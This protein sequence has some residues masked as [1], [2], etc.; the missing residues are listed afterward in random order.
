MATRKETAQRKALL[1]RDLRAARSEGWLAGEMATSQRELARKYGLSSFTVRQEM[2]LLAEEGVLHCVPR[3]GT[4]AGKQT[5]RGGE[6]YLLLTRDGGAGE[7]KF[8]QI[9]SGFEAALAQRGDAVLALEKSAAIERCRRRAMPP[10]VGI[11]DLAYWAYEQAWELPGQE[12]GARVA[13]AKPLETRPGYDLVS[14]DEVEGG[15]LAARHLIE[16]GHRQIAFLGVHSPCGESGIVQWS[17]QRQTGWREALQ[18]EGL[19]ADAVFL[20]ARDALGIGAPATS[21]FATAQEFA[22]GEFAAAR[23]SDAADELAAVGRFDNH[24]LKLVVQRLAFR[25]DI[26]AVVCA[27]DGAALELLAALRGARIEPHQWPAIVGFDNSALAQQQSITS[28]QLPSDELGRAAGQ[29]LW[30]RHNLTEN[31]DLEHRRVPMRLIPRLSSHACWPQHADYQP[32]AP[33]PN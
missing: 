14:F 30:E 22:D 32:A 20:P 24:E 15:R 7:A 9:Q 6:F 13:L 21:E 29:L 5:G 10:L 3:V 19:E 8:R 28:M 16:R 23:K 33:N 4:F 31:S 26:S 11:F 18:A 27:N 17:A 1:R 12:I 25:R 2:K